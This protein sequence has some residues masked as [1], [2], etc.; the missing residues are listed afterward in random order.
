MQLSRG[1][2]IWCWICF[3]ANGLL[4]IGQTVYY[5]WY[6]SVRRMPHFF[7]LQLLP[8]LLQAGA[9]A[10]YLYLI[11]GKKFGVILLWICAVCNF[12]Y[13]AYSFTMLLTM[14]RV[15]YAELIPRFLGMWVNPVVTTLVVH[16]AWR[17]RPPVPG[18]MAGFPGYP[19]QVQQPY[20]ERLKRLHEGM[21]A[22]EA[23][24][25]IGQPQFAMEQAAAFAAFGFVPEE[26]KGKEN[27]VYR[28]PYGEFQLVI[29]Q[30]KTVVGFNNL[31]GV[32]AEAQKKG[33]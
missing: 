28:S 4:V 20:S 23:V 22:T 1:Q 11:R 21:A 19:V 18:N 17:P 8:L 16:A 33:D 31:G 2:R 26:T 5:L 30:K 24:A 3:I 25:L 6:Y 32:I 9:V 27:W 14:P 7:L 12:S 13:L 29:F 10:A 15:N